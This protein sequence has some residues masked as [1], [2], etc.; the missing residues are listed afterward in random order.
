MNLLLSQTLL[1]FSEDCK[2]WYAK[3]A[4]AINKKLDLGLFSEEH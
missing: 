3:G 1:A 2:E 4:E